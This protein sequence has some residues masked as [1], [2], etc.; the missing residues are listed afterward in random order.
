MQDEPALG[1]LSPT[2]IV[3]LVSAAGNAV[4]RVEKSPILL[5]I[6]QNSCRQACFPVY[7][8]CYR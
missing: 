2:S 6:E 8:Q 1:Q 3:I 5:L 7:C 4:S